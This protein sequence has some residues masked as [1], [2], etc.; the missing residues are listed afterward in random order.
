MPLARRQFFRQMFNGVGAAAALPALGLPA[1]AVG[2]AWPGNWRTLQAGTPHGPIRLDSNEN[3]YGPSPQAYAA[4]EG[5]AAMANRY[6][7]HEYED[8]V[9]AI[10]ARHGVKAEQVLLGCGSSENLRMAAAALLEPGKT[11]LYADPTFELIVHQAASTGAQMVP[12]P[13][14]K[15]YAHDLDGILERAAGGSGL[16]YICNPNNPTGTL[17]P[18][19]DLEVFLRK[20]PPSY[21]VL[22]DEAYHHFVVGSPDYVSFLDRPVD[23]PRL[24]VTR[25]FSKIYG[26]AGMRIGYGVAAADTAR[27]LAARRMLFAVGVPAAR[28][29]LAAWND[30]ETVPKGAARNA[31]DRQEFYRQAKS[32]SLAVIDSQTNFVMVH[33]GRPAQDVIEHF[34]QNNV[35]IG[36]PFPPMTDYVRVSLGTPTDMQEFWRVWDLLPPQKA[37][38]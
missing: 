15:N 35:L 9:S 22:M 32:R 7:K 28:T 19:Q 6:P 23:D 8:L 12:V 33:S 27:V 4:L 24:I 38:S 16:V 21:T 31:A 18:R 3:A 37:A 5:S 20:L 1:E 2:S 11:L 10:A 29:A 26:L 17:T 36:R 13:L 30:A 34:R 14:T 25:T